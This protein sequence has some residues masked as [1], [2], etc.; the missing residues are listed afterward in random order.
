MRILQMSRCFFPY[1]AGATIRTYQ[2]AKNLV[3]Q[4]HDV[5]LL[6]HHP[7]GVRHATL[8]GDA[9]LKENYGGIHVYRLPYFGPPYLYYFLSVPIMAIEAIK[10][11]KKESIDA[12]LSENPPYIVGLA[13]YAAAKATRTSFFIDAHDPWGSSHHKKFE[14]YLGMILEGFC[15]RKARAIFCASKTIP[16]TLGKK[17]GIKPEK[18][19][20]A[21]N[22]VD[23][24]EF[25]VKKASIE[26]VRRK[27]KIPDKKIVLFVGSL[28]KWNGVQY[29]I[30]A[31]NYIKSDCIVIIAGG[32]ID[33]DKFKKQA[34]DSENIMFTGIV[35]Y[36][37]VAPLIGLADICVA[38]L[39]KVEN[40]GW[41][42]YEA[43]IPIH[44]LEYMAAGKPIVGSD[45]H[46]VNELLSGGRGILFKAEDAEDL[47]RKIRY[48]LQNKQEG[49][50]MGERAKEYVR[51]N[52]CWGRAAK[53]IEDVM[54]GALNE[55]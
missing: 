2:I 38:P 12:I 21:L 32:G 26:I 45:V 25:K 48:L 10:I 27:Y 33:E 30:E 52:Y 15:C 50:A 23:T 11:I 31:A 42:S 17:Y 1:Q 3:K 9:P 29:L 36:D 4:G 28:A 14:Y 39:P 8:N 47:A 34:A 54:E 49:E 6:V 51:E 44:L 18:C 5:H 19:E 43:P 16:K 13:S 46:V 40:V 22:G 24:N 53:I 55:K 35:P 20:L 37:D 41:E 7:N